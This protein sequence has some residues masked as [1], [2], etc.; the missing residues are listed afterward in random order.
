MPSRKKLEI[1][2]S[3]LVPLI[4]LFLIAATSFAADPKPAAPLKT[5]TYDVSD[6]INPSRPDDQ[7][8]PTPAKLT[9]D[10]PIGA[11]SPSRSEC[12]KSLASMLRDTIDPNSWQPTG[13][14]S[15]TVDKNTFVIS[16]TAE[17]HRGIANLLRQLRE[18]PKAQKLSN[19]FSTAPRLPKNTRFDK[20]ELT[21][22]VAAIAKAA[23]VPIEL[24]FKSSRHTAS[25]STPPSPPTSPAKPRPAPS[26]P[27]SAPPPTAEISASRSTP[28]AA[29][30]RSASTPARRLTAL[31]ACTT[32]GCSPPAPP[33]STPSSRT[34]DRT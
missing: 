25:R 2:C 15:L 12:R 16:Q 17:N 32:S 22:A 9:A 24:N 1:A 14:A 20:T 13:P 28:A 4:A 5:L 10:M 23:N 19:T 11:P 6:F 34:Q 33:A 27:S 26:A 7:P 3:G 30:S 31:V 8:D 29:R 18:D 21:L